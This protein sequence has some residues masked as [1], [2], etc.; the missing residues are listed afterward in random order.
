MPSKRNSPR[1]FS[2]IN[3]E[4]PVPVIASATVI[5]ISAP[6]FSLFFGVAV[7]FVWTSCSRFSEPT[8]ERFAPQTPQDVSESEL[9]EPHRGHFFNLA[10]DDRLLDCAGCLSRNLDARV[11][12]G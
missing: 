2:N 8:S 10:L 5:R 12:S 7:D 6:R 11:M 9:I 3:R 1:A 4:N